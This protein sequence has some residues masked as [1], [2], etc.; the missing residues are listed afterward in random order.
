M[1]VT[2]DDKKL[3]VMWTL[4]SGSTVA[5]G[6][7]LVQIQFEKIFDDSSENIIWQ[8]NI[9][10]FEI[11]DSLD[12][13]DEIADQEPTLFQQWEEK[14]STLYSDAAADVQSM[15]ALQGLAKEYSAAAAVSAQSAQQQAQT[16]QEA[17]MQVQQK[18]NDFSGYTKKEIDNGFACALIGKAM[19]Q[20]IVL[21]DIQP[22]TN[23]RS[24]IVTGQ[25][26]ETG[27][28]DKSPNNPY[29]LLGATKATISDDGKNPQVMNLPQAL[30]SL[31]DGTADSCDVVSGQGI[32]KIGKI[33]LDGSAPIYKFTAK[34]GTEES[35]AAFYT[36]PV[37]G[38]KKPSSV[39]ADVQ[40]LLSSHF[41]KKGS[42]NCE[43]LL[44]KDD[45]SFISV[46]PSGALIFR[47]PKSCMNGW[48]DTWADVQK[49]AAVQSW[50]SSHPVTVLY[51]LAASLTVSGESLRIPAY[52]PA[53]VISTDCG[54]VSVAYIRD[55][56]AVLEKI[57]SAFQGVS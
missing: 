40:W 30:Y 17:A 51:E 18:V 45:E 34:S 2:A 22:N 47:I 11:P 54:S 10:E 1:E 13:A 16:A 52:A 6:K 29:A 23:L 32:G 57:E 43:D 56:N 42:Y 4:M 12:A 48:L 53:S 3:S 20:S 37:S 35:T 38:I 39:N 5:A 28:G 7:L 14:V 33:T 15:Q 26:A 36:S 44:W 55:I 41:V 19:G 21:D 24:L 31:S 9:M 8:S 49:A 50:L 46:R 27:S 25:T